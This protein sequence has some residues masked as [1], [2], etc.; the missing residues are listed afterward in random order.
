MSR[1]DMSVEAVTARLREMSR[2]SDLS[3]D[4]RLAAKVD[5][6]SEGVSRRLRLQSRLREACLKWQRIGE[7]N[8]LGRRATDRSD[9]A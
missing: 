7:A 4:K 3:P 2:L 5:M 1:V 9:D 6:S 8:G